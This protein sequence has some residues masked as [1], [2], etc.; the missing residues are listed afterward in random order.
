MICLHPSCQWQVL[1]WLGCT[2]NYIL[3]EHWQRGHR[4]PCTGGI[5]F[6]WKWAEQTQHSS[7][8]SSHNSKQSKCNSKTA[9]TDNPF[10]RG[11]LLMPM[12]HRH[13]CIITYDLL[14]NIWNDSE[15]QNACFITYDL[16]YS[17][18][19]KYSHTVCRYAGK[20]WSCQHRALNST[21]YI[22]IS[23]LCSFTFME[24]S[25]S[26]ICSSYHSPSHSNHYNALYSSFTE[27]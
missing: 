22:F 15:P 18:R 12:D 4:P 7:V 10:S 25:I 24:R 11:S 17:A 2:H 3:L 21:V 6:C 14:Y 19:S 8:Y 23:Y 5:L 26:R 16:I 13:A 9:T 1:H 27:L 20:K